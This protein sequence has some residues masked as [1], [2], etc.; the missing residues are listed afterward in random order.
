M[1]AWQAVSVTQ[2]D[3]AAQELRNKSLT[4]HYVPPNVPTLH[5]NEQAFPAIKVVVDEFF[6]VKVPLYT[7]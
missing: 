7:F 6:R 5:F 4:L 2:A 1:Q 3:A